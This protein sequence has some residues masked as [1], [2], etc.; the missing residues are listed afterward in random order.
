MKRL[1]ALISV[2]LLVLTACSTSNEDSKESKDSDSTNETQTKAKAKPT[3]NEGDLK[4][5]AESIYE[6]DERKDI[7]HLK[8]IASDNVQGIINRQFQGANFKNSDR[9]DKTASNVK[10]YKNVD[11]NNTYLAT[12][13]VKTRDTKAKKMV[14]LQ[15]TLEFKIKNGKVNEFQEIGD[16]EIFNEQD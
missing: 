2:S 14:W 15:K 9:Y 12:M 1:I 7:A 3:I 11:T 10:L 16:R 4:E 5:F 13:E 8:S 6:A